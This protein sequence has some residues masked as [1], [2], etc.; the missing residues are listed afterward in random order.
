MSI[1]N[2]SKDCII[3]FRDLIEYQKNRIIRFPKLRNLVK[4][5]INRGTQL[6]KIK[7]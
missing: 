7:G 5:F 2:K 6:N 3:T 1:F 4:C